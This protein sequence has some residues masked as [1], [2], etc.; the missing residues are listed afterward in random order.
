MEIEIVNEQ[1][2]PYD[3]GGVKRLLWNVKT[4][5]LRSEYTPFRPL[6]WDTTLKNF[7]FGFFV[8]FT[9]I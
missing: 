7:N 4:I 3:G 6:F 2:Q 5:L 9:F 8:F 1:Q